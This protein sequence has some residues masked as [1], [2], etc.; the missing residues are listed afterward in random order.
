[1]SI[2]VSGSTSMYIGVHFPL[3]LIFMRKNPN[4]L[5]KLKEAAAVQES[6]NTISL[7]QTFPKSLYWRIVEFQKSTGLSTEQE[8][9]RVICT[10]FLAKNGH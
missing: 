8:A 1:M 9:V 7:N 5:Q 4:H 10:M 2:I 6:E 3:N